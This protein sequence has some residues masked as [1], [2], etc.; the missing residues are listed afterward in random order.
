[1]KIAIFWN[2]MSCNVVF[3]KNIYPVMFSTEV[4]S[5]LKKEASCVSEMLVTV[6]QTTQCQI[7]QD[8][9]SS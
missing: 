8:S 9:I 2:V 5:V 7:R 1:M 6:S 3:Q 4:L